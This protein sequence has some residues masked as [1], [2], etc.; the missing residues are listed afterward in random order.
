MS[1]SEGEDLFFVC[2]WWG[3]SDSD[4]ACTSVGIKSAD[5][6]WGVGDG[7]EAGADSSW[8]NG[9]FRTSVSKIS[10]KQTE[11]QNFLIPDIVTSMIAVRDRQKT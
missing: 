4:H 8:L 7:A 10:D 1:R 2:F 5:I 3:S 6:L 11:C 9:L